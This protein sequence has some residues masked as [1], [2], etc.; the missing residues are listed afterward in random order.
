MLLNLS[1][2]VYYIFSSSTLYFVLNIQ[3]LNPKKSLEF[4]KYN[5]SQSFKRFRVNFNFKF[6]PPKRFETKWKGQYNILGQ[7]KANLIH[8]RP[9]SIFVM[10][11]EG[12]LVCLFVGSG[13]SQNI[14]AIARLCF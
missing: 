11:T 2:N 4:T 7:V 3:R 6:I 9:P 13:Q 1:Y 14:C 12:K 5:D 8:F 10:P